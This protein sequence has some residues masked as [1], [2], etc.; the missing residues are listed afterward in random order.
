[1]FFKDLYKHMYWADAVAWRA[2]FATAQTEADARVRELLYH[3]HLTQTAFLSIWHR[4]QVDFPK[5][6][7]FENLVAI[8]KW[9]YEYH[10][11]VT[12][13]LNKIG[14][15]SLDNMIDIPWAK[16]FIEE[17]LGKTPES[18]TLAETILQ[19][20]LHSTHHR[21]QVMARLRELGDEPPLTDFIAWV[22]LGKP[23]ADWP[24]A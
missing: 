24:N 9:G 17:K 19:V 22:W 14:K 5:P 4:Q 15:S 12:R 10:Q 16:R 13:Y 7:D 23:G 6:T 18:A 1:M 3:I 8:S 20:S 21:G 11:D 2:I